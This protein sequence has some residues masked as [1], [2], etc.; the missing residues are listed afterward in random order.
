MTA[1]AIVVLGILGMPFFGVHLMTDKS[2]SGNR[3]LGLAITIVGFIL[4]AAFFGH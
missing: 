4:W 3:L 2:Q 1:V